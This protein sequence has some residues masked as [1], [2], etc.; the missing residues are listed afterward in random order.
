[1]KTRTL[2]I[3]AVTIFV[4]LIATSAA[5]S[6]GPALASTA[7]NAA[8]PEPANAQLPVRTATGE[9]R[10]TNLQ[11]LLELFRSSDNSFKVRAINSALKLTSEEAQKFWPV[12][13]Q[14]EKA[15]QGQMDRRIALIKEFVALSNE[16]KINNENANRLSGEWLKLEEDRV[17]TWKKYYQEISKAVSPLRGAQF[18]QVENQLAILMDLNIAGAMP[19]VKGSK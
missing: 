5:L 9:T 17:E 8:P 15:Q 3:L 10:P 16:G 1:M 18:L 19:A 7:G 6:R 14:Y 12:Y 4:A 13:Q 2:G 11:Q